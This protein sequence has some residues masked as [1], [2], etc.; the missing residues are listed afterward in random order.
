MSAWP[1]WHLLGGAP[2]TPSYST[3]VRALFERVRSQQEQER[4]AR[5]RREADERESANE[6]EADGR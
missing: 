1:L 2:Y 6:N 5:E 3:N 4:I